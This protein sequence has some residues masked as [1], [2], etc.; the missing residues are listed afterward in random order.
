MEETLK[1]T[2]K[3]TNRPKYLA[4]ARFVLAFF[5][6]ILVGFSVGANAKAASLYFSPSSGSYKVGQQFSV[7][8]YVGSAD[9]AMNAAEGAISFPEDMLSVVSISKSGSIAS[10][11]AQEPS[12]SNSAGT[13]DF[14]GIVLNPGYTGGAGKIL[15]V[16]FKAKAKGE[17]SLNFSSASVLANDGLGSNIFSGAGTAVF[18]ITVAAVSPTGAAPPATLP[19]GAIGNVPAAPAV[20]S[21]THPDPEKWYNNKNP[22]FKWTMPSGITG[23][24]VLADRNPLTDPGTKSD[25]LLSSYKY[26]D[27]DEGAWYFHVKL[28]NSAGWGAMAHFRFNIGTK[29]PTS[30]TITEIPRADQTEAVAKFNFNAKDSGSGIDHYEVVFDDETAPRIW[31]DDGTHI[32][33]APALPP[34]KHLLKAKVI[35]GVGNFLEASVEFNIA[36]LRAPVITEYS[37]SLKS[38]ESLIVKGTTYPNIKVAIWLK[39]DLAEPREYEV[40]SDNNGNFAFVAPEKTK[41]GLYSV[42]AEVIGEAGGRSEPSETVKTLVAPGLIERISRSAINFLVVFI[43]LIVLLF[44]LVILIWYIWHR[45]SLLRKRVKK[46][47]REAG[48]KLHKAIDEM[49]ENMRVHVRSLQRIKNRRDLTIAENRILGQLKKNIERIEK[50]IE[51]EMGD[52]EKDVK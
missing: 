12:F 4:K 30:F 47:A 14:A 16:T 37:S 48:D 29:P 17:A 20:S 51:K 36:G 43:P 32:Y 10:L 44:L 21:P 8:V 6:F 46:D 52:I 23:V 3:N 7:G 15:T 13:V 31:K 35:D 19:G 34:G 5:S 39:K 2:N 40:R 45:F 50:L 26:S 1:P 42:Y 41:E 24:N 27:V 28:K 11:W 22:E 25:G 33:A 38:G 18:T 9:A 49:T